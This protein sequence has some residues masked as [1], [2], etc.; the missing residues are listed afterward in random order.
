VCTDLVRS[1]HHKQLISIETSSLNDIHTCAW[2]GATGTAADDDA[3]GWVSRGGS[4]AVGWDGYR[5]RCV[6]F[7]RH[8]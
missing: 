6:V 1:G 7:G 2:A 8:R 5:G 4:W 3:A